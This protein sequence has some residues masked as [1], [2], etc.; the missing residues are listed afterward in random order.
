M[1]ASNKEYLFMCKSESDRD[2]DIGEFI[3]GKAGSHTHSRHLIT[4]N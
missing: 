1:N 3:A 2:G 4:K